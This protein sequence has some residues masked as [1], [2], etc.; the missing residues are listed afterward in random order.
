MKITEQIDALETLAVDPV[1]YLVVPKFL[2]GLVMFP[3]LT[4]LADALHILGGYVIGITTLNL[5]TGL[6]FFQAFRFITF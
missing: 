1:E 6:F 4:I 2:A 5:S 3:V